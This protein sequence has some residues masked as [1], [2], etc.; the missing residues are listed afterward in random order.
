MKN[1]IISIIICCV[2]LVSGC[3]ITVNSDGTIS[4]NNQGT[5]N[6][7]LANPASTFCIERG[8]TNE[9]RTSPDGS[10]TGYCVFPDGSE[11]EE[12]AF[13]RGTCVA[14][15]TQVESNHET[16]NSNQNDNTGITVRLEG[17]LM[18]SNCVKLSWDFNGNDISF[19]K[20]V[21]SVTNSNPKYPEDG[22]IDVISD[23]S[24]TSY[25]DCSLD[26]TKTNYYRITAVLPSGEYVHSNV[27][28][29]ESSNRQVSC[30]SNWECTDW[31]NCSNQVRERTCRDINNCQNNDARPSER[32]TCTEA[33]TIKCSTNNDCNDNNANTLD[34][35]SNPGSCRAECLSTEKQYSFSITNLTCNSTTGMITAVVANIGNYNIERNTWYSEV[36]GVQTAFERIV[37]T[38]MPIINTGSAETISFSLDPRDLLQ[39]FAYTVN[40]SVGVASEIG[41]CTAQ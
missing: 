12:W 3:T 13:Y 27:I 11:C 39:N 28:I 22:Y 30:E 7:Q 26:S 19:Y 35:C 21:R 8:Y 18:D 23:R 1:I 29:I 33:C 2:L 34:T 38:S 20:V 10:Q 6:T 5:N 4:G 17:E 14:G 36:S 15:N 9:I 37:N 32:E 25:I 41:S 16:G 24:M 40:I 31:N